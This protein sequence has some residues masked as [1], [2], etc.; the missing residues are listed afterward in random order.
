MPCP[1][2]GQNPTINY[3]LFKMG[4]CFSSKCSQDV[5]LTTPRTS[6]LLE[7]GHA[8]TFNFASHETSVPIGSAS[9]LYKPEIQLDGQPGLV[10]SHPQF[11]GNHSSEKSSL[12]YTHSTPCFSEAPRKKARVTFSIPPPPLGLPPTRLVSHD[13]NGNTVSSL[14]RYSG[15]SF[16]LN[17][18]DEHDTDQD[19]VTMTLLE[20]GPSSAHSIGNIPVRVERRGYNTAMGVQMHHSAFSCVMTSF[21]TH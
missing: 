2:E 7:S 16:F 4:G 5:I 20:A 15:D 1:T 21:C 13:K 14:S 19:H 18:I 3:W 6:P 9:P 10:S 11:G 12:T 8:G 17:S